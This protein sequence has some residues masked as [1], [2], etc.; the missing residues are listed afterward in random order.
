MPDEE[1]SEEEPEKFFNAD[2]EPGQAPAPR[3]C[4][5]GAAGV[6]LTLILVGFRLL[7]YSW[8]LAGTL[9]QCHWRFS[10]LAG[11]FVLRRCRLLV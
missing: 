5:A 4:C 2:R 1:S 3:G 11:V 6:I 7:L 9:I 8:S 10:A